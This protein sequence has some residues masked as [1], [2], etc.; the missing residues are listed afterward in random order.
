M[1]YSQFAIAHKT[2][3]SSLLQGKNKTVP[4]R[5]SAISQKRQTAIEGMNKNLQAMKGLY[6]EDREN[7]TP[8]SILSERESPEEKEKEVLKGQIGMPSGM[9]GMPFT[10]PEVSKEQ[11]AKDITE[12]MKKDKKVWLAY[13]N[14]TGEE[15]KIFMELAEKFYC[16]FGNMG[17]MGMGGY[18]GYGSSMAGGEN[19]PGGTS[20]YLLTL[21]KD[22]KLQNKDIEG[23]TLL[24]NLNNFGKQKFR[25]GI[26]GDFIL[27]EILGKVSTPDFMKLLAEQ[28]SSLTEE[29]RLT[30]DNPSEYTR[31]IKGLT[32]E[33]G[34]VKLQNG[35]TLKFSDKSFQ[36]QG[37]INCSSIFQ[38]SMEEN[39]KN[40]TDREQIRKDIKNQI[41][42]DNGALA[43]YGTMHQ[44]EKDKFMTLAE[45]FYKPP[46]DERP[47]MTDEDL[48]KLLGKFYLQDRDSEGKDFLDNLIEL[49][50]QKFPPGINKDIIICE[51][52]RSTA[53]PESMDKKNFTDKMEFDLAS[54]NAAEYIRIITGLTGEKGEV[55]LKDGSILKRNDEV[56]ELYGEIVSPATL[57]GDSM[58]MMLGKEKVR[59]L[60]REDIMEGL[61]K[62]EALWK[63]YE[64]MTEKERS[65]FLN[66]SEKVYDS[67]SGRSNLLKLLK[68]DKIQNKD[69][70]GKT[71]LDN[72]ISLES[73][74]QDG[75]TGLNVLTQ[76][77]R[78][79]TTPDNISRFDYPSELQKK[80][81]KNSSAE[82]VRIISGLTD[83]K[84]EVLLQNGEI[85]KRSETIELSINVD[86]GEIYRKS[87]EEHFGTEKLKELQRQDIR[88]KI[89]ENEKAR[90]NFEH[91]SEDDR[92]RTINLM[93]SLY[94]KGLYRDIL[95][96]LERD[97]LYNRDSKGKTLIE[98]LTEMN[99][100]KPAEGLNKAGVLYT[101]IKNLTEPGFMELSREKND[102]THLED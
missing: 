15:K 77:I 21:L 12:E 9:M 84:G 50:D 61:K 79:L 7:L 91:M 71:L 20:I 88:D 45:K 46:M 24:E 51:V 38:A 2:G 63:K 97:K 76:V 75:I 54:S 96:L 56:V 48:I 78:S 34:E 86:T 80:I 58:R 98:N 47:G 6:E 28:N 67:S 87:I 59:E 53:R 101:L 102:Y 74:F 99:N 70:T 35:E 26:T 43:A 82:Y 89:K 60:K 17:G 13:E 1:D 49:E 11:K 62:D 16:P 18:G 66:L 30:K 65:D 22:G 69:T 83:E 23:K 10:M 25:Q 19:M 29:Y 40:K 81:L 39:A 31:I 32:S 92:E 85:L 4:V 90:I 94:T 41:F 68:K 36:G 5:S 64:N 93:D 72:L 42:K 95:K 27:G 52:I 44:E 33:E 37:F 57:Y 8:V 100:L 73:Q 55:K 3:I 14:M